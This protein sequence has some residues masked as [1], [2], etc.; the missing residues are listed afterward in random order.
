M[1]GLGAASSAVG[2]KYTGKVMTAGAVLVVVLGLSMLFPMA[3]LLKRLCDGRWE[4][5]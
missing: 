3:W 2:K 5:N 1:F 4:K